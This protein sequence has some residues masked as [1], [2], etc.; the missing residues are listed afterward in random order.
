MAQERENWRVRTVTQLAREL[1][2]VVESRRLRI[3]RRSMSVWHRRALHIATHSAKVAHDEKSIEAGARQLHAVLDRALLRRKARVWARLVGSAIATAGREE[4]SREVL[5][6]HDRLL[7]VAKARSSRRIVAGAWRAWKSTWVESRHRGEIKSLRAQRGVGM[8]VAITRRKQLEGLRIAMVSWRARGCLARERERAASRIATCLLRA[9]ARWKRTLAAR[10][11]LRWQLGCIM[12]GKAVAEEGKASAEAA[13]R[14]QAVL[15][16]IRRHRLHRLGEAFRCLFHHKTVTVYGTRQEEARQAGFSRGLRGLGRMVARKTQ[17]QLMS[18]FARWRWFAAGVG[19][20]SD[21]ALLVS[22]RKRAGAQSL[23]SLLTRR[24]RGKVI[25]AWTL[26]RSG[27]ASAAVHDGERASA[28]LRVSGARHSAAARLLLITLSAARRRAMGKAWRLWYMEVRE[29]GEA[30][31]QTM[32]K[33]FH[34]ARMLNRVEKGIELESLERAWHVWGKRVIEASSLAKI[35]G[36]VRRS[37][38]THGFNRWRLTCHRIRLAEADTGR[39]S[40]EAALR[41]KAMSI[42]TK[43]HKLR[44]LREG[45]S[46]LFDHGAW[47]IYFSKEAAARRDRL[48]QGLHVLA[49]SCARRRERDKLRVLGRWQR[50]TSE[51]RRQDDRALLQA[52]GRRAGAKSLA[53]LVARR[54][55]MCLGRS[56]GIWR[57]GAASAAV[58]DGERASADQRVF[59]ARRSAGARLLCGVVA[60]TTRRTLTKAWVVWCKEAKAAADAELQVMEKH[61]HLARTL[62]RVERRVQIAR[63]GRTWRAWRDVVRVQGEAELQ[64]LERQFHVAQVLLRVARRAQ[65]RRLSRAWGLWARLAARGSVKVR[66]SLTTLSPGLLAAAHASQTVPARSVLG[67]ADGP[68]EAVAVDEQRAQEQAERSRRVRHRAGAVTIRGLLRRADSRSLARVWQIWRAVTVAEAD[69]KVRLVVG[70]TRLAKVFEGLAE[71]REVNRL[72]RFWGMW[73]GWS[74]AEGRR[75]EHIAEA[76][77]WL[78][79]EAKARELKALRAA[80][81]LAIVID[82]SEARL[83][84][85][86]LEKWTQAASSVDQGDGAFDEA[87]NI[88]ALVQQPTARGD[89]TVTADEALGDE[90]LTAAAAPPPVATAAATSPSSGLV[91]LRHKLLGGPSPLLPSRLDVPPDARCSPVAAAPRSSPMPRAGASLLRQIRASAS[92]RSTSALSVE[93][94]EFRM[95]QG[96]LHARNDGRTWW[97]G[98]S[99][100]ESSLLSTSPHLMNVIGISATPSAHHNDDIALQYSQQLGTPSSF[101]SLDLSASPEQPM[102]AFRSHSAGDFV[103]PLSSTFSTIAVGTLGSSAHTAGGHAAGG[104]ATVMT[105]GEIA[106][107][108]PSLAY[109]S[110]SPLLGESVLQSR[111]D[112]MGVG[113]D[114]DLEQGELVDSDGTTRERSPGDGQDDSHRNDNARPRAESQDVATGLRAH[115]GTPER[116]RS[117]V[118]DMKSNRGY[119][120]GGEKLW[121]RN[122]QVVTSRQHT[123]PPYVPGSVHASPSGNQRSFPLDEVEEGVE[124]PN[125]NRF[126]D[127][128]TEAF[129]FEKTPEEAW[130]GSEGEEG[131][132]GSSS[133]ETGKSS[134]ELFMARMRVVVFRQAFKRWLLVHRD[135][136]YDLRMMTARKKVKFKE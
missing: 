74:A 36:R 69:R 82:R 67:A 116:L 53:A 103:G 10:C 45:F 41:A 23:V 84:R 122:Q 25:R 61:F 73:A 88:A 55:N 44:Q 65:E 8:V 5:A 46:R 104:T 109:T 135:A 20:Q 118:K 71:S 48:A 58:H 7:A 66:G 96:E 95:E 38:L 102:M 75:L 16:I 60:A 43:R 13:Y 70:V 92:P 3:L 112:I 54:E 18:A 24:E 64:T 30:E 93:G 42:L 76:N 72:R 81:V 78:V 90:R 50:F 114:E 9:D 107:P 130:H 133:D 125:S 49:R 98:D 32:E 128:F 100:G 83:V 111:S 99:S 33:H 97:A 52:T 129:H 40:A 115:F 105:A 91:A 14:A 85:A 126:K 2:R 86:S 35:V 106:S 124:T 123:L 101:G 87:A 39:A 34:L 113:E 6:H 77:K 94:S 51:R 37:Q 59:G 119:P 62:T 80:R 47:V 108:A 68:A 29:A 117:E 57:T 11:L 89:N 15:A 63:V 22:S 28:D 12:R 134:A 56:W 21:R 19:Q 121:G 4:R 131:G 27:A 132:G 1:A 79:A 26:W 136:D 127:T 110:E 31:L 17:R 120:S